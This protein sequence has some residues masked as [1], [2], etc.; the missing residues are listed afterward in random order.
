MSTLK[1]G[2]G[3]TMAFRAFCLDCETFH[4]IRTA[5]GTPLIR[6]MESWEYKHR[7]HRIEFSS[8]DRDI[9]RDL[10]DSEFEKLGKAPWW[11]NFKENNNFQF[12]FVA[13]ANLTYTSLNSLGSDTNLLAGA[14]SLDVDNGATG[15]PLEIGVTGYFKN[16]GTTPTVGKEI[17]VYAYGRIDDTHWPDTIDG[18][19]ATKTIT[20]ANILNSGFRQM[21]S[22]I[23]AATASQVNPMAPVALS[24]LFG[25]MPRYWGVFT[26]HNSGQSL[27]SGGNQVT[28]KGVY[29]QG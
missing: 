3:V 28:Y 18:T 9:P 17:D 11:A 27:N 26:V 29:V 5:P 12:A 8:Q 19:D 23:I 20:T 22:L 15:A 13:A 21:A 24:A 2:N 16:S 10:D 25:V 14:A 6:E 1:S 4:N 7:G